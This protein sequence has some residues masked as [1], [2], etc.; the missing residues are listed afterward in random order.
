MIWM[1]SGRKLSTK[2]IN[3]M[4][5]RWTSLTVISRW[6]ASDSVSCSSWSSWRWSSN[7][8]ATLRVCTVASLLPEFLALGVAGGGT[9]RRPLAALARAHAAL[10]VDALLLDASQLLLEPVRGQVD[11]L[12]HLGR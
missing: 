9:V 5:G 3:A 2:P 8:R 12:A 4:P 10:L 1:R 11:R 7:N 6:D